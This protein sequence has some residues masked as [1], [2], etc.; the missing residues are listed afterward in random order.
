MNDPSLAP[1]PTRVVIRPP[2][3]RGELAAGISTEGAPSSNLPGG[4]GGESAGLAQAD[5]QRDPFAGWIDAGPR[6][7]ATPTAPAAPQAAPPNNLAIAAG[8]NDIRP[9]GSA[10]SSTPPEAAPQGDPWA[11]W[12]DAGPGSAP[13]HEVGRGHAAL[14]G[15]LDTAGFGFRD[16]IVGL[17]EA[18]GLPGW[19]GGL[20]APVGAARLGIEALQGQEGPASRNYSEARDRTREVQK[21]AE[22]QH[23]GYYLTGQLGGAVLA[24]GA[25][26]GAAAKGA[27]ALMRAKRAATVGGVTGGIYGVG[28]GQGAADRAT[29]GAVGAGTGAVIGGV[30][31]P[32][33]DVAGYGFRKGAGAVR[34]AYNAI[35]ADLNPET[36]QRIVGD[37][38]AKR[39]VGARAAD[40]EAHGAQWTPEEIAAAQAGN[41]PRSIVDV[42]G[43]RTLA[44]ARSA[45]NQSPEARAALTNLA[46]DRFAGQSRRAADLIERMTGRA[47][48][49][50]VEPQPAR[51]GRAIRSVAGDANATAELERLREAGRRANRPAYARA[52]AAGDREIW[53]PELERLT[54]APSI[55]QSMQAAVNKWRDWQVVDGFGGA[56]PGATIARGQ[57]TFQGGRYGV[58]TFPNVQFWDYTARNIADKAEAARRAGRGQLAAQ[59]GGLERQLKAELDRL[60]PEYQEARQGAA[61]FFGAADALEAGR[62]FAR[63][64]ANIEEAR[65]AHGQFSPAEREL[66]ARG[67][68]SELADQAERARDAGNLLDSPMF[69]SAAGR[70]KT[71]LALGPQR[72]ERL[73][74]AL[75]PDRAFHAFDGA[76]SPLEAGR[77]FVQSGMD[78]P[79]ARAAIARIP[80]EDR[81]AFARGFASELADR[82]LEMRD[83]QDV[84][85]QAFLTS[86]AAKQRIEMALGPERARQLEVYLRAESLVD[87]LRT[88]LGNSTTARQLAEMGLAGAGTLAIGHGAVEGEWDARHALTAA[89]LFG[90]AYGKHRSQVLDNS[91]ARRI[92]EMLAS[93]DPQV[94]QRGIQIV[95]KSRVWLD[96]LR[97]A[98]DKISSAL[99]GGVVPR[100]THVLL[101]GPAHGNAKAEQGQ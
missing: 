55:R 101:Q 93:N 32:L 34:S 64:S 71:E 15:A 82:I 88:A 73:E 58:P 59:L 5:L 18:S 28:S 45:A 2:W 70:Q 10:P 50:A 13:K 8:L 23:P 94:L 46:Q 74:Q 21:A 61:R 54:S 37:E 20:R 91:V 99:S 52:Y 63:S 17:S 38:A 19:L 69:A 31:S 42:G 62:A 56:N 3:A 14:E 72:V 16:E 36:G 49:A 1:A 39:I 30:A 26:A 66:F 84:I 89:V 87:R 79:A 4:L 44:L 7:A 67:Y 86:P 100:G 40:L 33:I 60:V 24:P 47:A 22:E 97:T 57:L 53:S 27:T 75:A 77:N 51:L 9:V 29:R 35:R 68:A 90:A 85:K 25:G 76:S 43:E 12:R 98:G 96:A 65:M 92:G 48:P 80:A 95:A 6:A 11:G 41:V 78:M 83:N 81:E